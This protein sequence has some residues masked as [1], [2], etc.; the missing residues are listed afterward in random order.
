MLTSFVAKTIRAT[1][2]PK[3]MIP[4]VMT[5]PRD[6]LVLYSLTKY[7]METI[8]RKMSEAMKS[9]VKLIHGLRMQAL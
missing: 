8:S 7:M 9:T 5:S 1:K 4:E 2:N 6:N 3:E